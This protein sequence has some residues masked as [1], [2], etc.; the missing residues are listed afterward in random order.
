MEDLTVIT[1]P[2]C[3]ADGCEPTGTL[4][5]PYPPPEGKSHASVMVCDEPAHRDRAAAWVAQ[6]TGLEATYQPFLEA[7]AGG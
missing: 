1:T 5:S 6:A 3:L 2:S 7:E 4:G